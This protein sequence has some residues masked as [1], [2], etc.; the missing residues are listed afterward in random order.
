MG[1]QLSFSFR[2]PEK[3]KRII[4]I[5]LFACTLAILA[6]CGLSASA[7]GNPAGTPAAAANSAGSA[8]ATA[9]PA[10]QGTPQ[11][12]PA[13]DTSAGVGIQV[14]S[15]PELNAE[16][17]AYGGMT[18]AGM[19]PGDYDAATAIPWTEA[20]TPG[21]PE[22][23]DIDLNGLMDYEAYERY[24]LNLGRYDGVAVTVIG[25][26]EM[27]RNIYMVTVD[28]SGE[29][30]GAKPLLMISGSVHA[31]EFAGAEYA[32]KC[33]NDTLAAAQTDEDTLA[34][35]E[36]AVIVAV[37]LVNPDGRELIIEGGDP[38]RK[39]NANGV[40]LNRALPSV[41]AGQLAWGEEFS[42]NFSVIP[43]MDFFAGYSLG[44]ESE[45]QAMIKW[46]NTYVPAAAAYIDLHQQGGVSFYEKD[47][48]SEASDDAC[49]SFAREVSGLLNSG[50][51]PR[52][53]QFGLNG[54]GGT[55]TDYARSV[56]EGFVYSYRLGRMALLIDGKET[57]LLCFGDID[58]C[59]EYYRPANPDFLS[60]TI[61]IGRS[62]SY[63][64][65]DESARA[66][67][68]REYRKYGWDGFLTGTIELLMDRQ[69]EG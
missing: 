37:P 55:M 42:D 49:R 28:L 10:L 39:S 22:Q 24:I 45:T 4:F 19:L 46:F 52:R 69:P 18:V 36:S 58:D 12:A 65:A 6:A 68:A 21:A 7:V 60:M 61:E 20:D 38:S 23:V 16:Y 43:C 29:G 31:R 5:G 40:D 1:K 54:D 56:A 44:S 47:F 48:L 32:V 35:L 66:L 17:A 3:R 13:P 9:A 59:M 8:A 14:A 50:Y 30:A 63:L 25:R 51:D 64:G 53:E 41:N 15:L 11:P 33:L 27:G 2:I 34:L 62:P 57:P 26:S 67:R